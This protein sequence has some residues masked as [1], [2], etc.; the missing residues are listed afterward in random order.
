MSFSLVKQNEMRKVWMK[1]HFNSDSMHFRK[2]DIVLCDRM[3]MLNLFVWN[4]VTA[5]DTHACCDRV[6][7]LLKNMCRDDTLTRQKRRK[8]HKLWAHFSSSQHI[9]NQF[10]FSP[11]SF[12]TSIAIN[13]IACDIFADNWTARYQTRTKRFHFEGD[14]KKKSS[15]IKRKA[16]G[17]LLSF[18]VVDV[19]ALNST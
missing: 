13:L 3:P 10:S 16:T 14:R 9:S 7:N 1:S 15:K 18:D 5:F 6:N 4:N 8:Y 19:G 17:K 12:H 2:R 11:F